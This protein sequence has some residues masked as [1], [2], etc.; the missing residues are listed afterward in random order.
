LSAFLNLTPTVQIIL[1][2]PFSGTTYPADGSVVATIDSGY[3]G[4]LA[5]PVNLYEQLR[6]NELQQTS[7]TLVLANGEILTS[8]GAYATLRLPH[9][10]AELDGFVETYQGLDEIIFGVEAL[11]HFSATLDYCSR[12]VTLHTAPETAHRIER[13]LYPYSDLSSERQ[14]FKRN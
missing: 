8:N 13:T 11:S 14:H 9:L 3:E 7:R 1:E 12:R 4:F 2:N 10:R 6:L 5:I